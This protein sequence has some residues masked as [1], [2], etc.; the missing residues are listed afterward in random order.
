M[1]NKLAHFAI[2]ADDVDRA[3]NFYG[4]VFGWTFEPWGPPNFYRIHGAGVQGALQ[5]RP[6]PA[7]LGKGGFEC[8][9]AVD[10]LAASLSAIREAGG[11]MLGSQHQ[12]PGVGSLAKFEDSEGNHVVIIQYE[13][14]V[15]SELGL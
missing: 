14:S 10:D 9:I 1:P 6:S 12:I 7:E 13:P 5:E 3:R 8:S 11:S 2:E 15:L 4:S